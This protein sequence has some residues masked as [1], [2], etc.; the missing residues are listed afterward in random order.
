MLQ[1]YDVKGVG[2]VGVKQRETVCRVGH[3]YFYYIAV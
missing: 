2:T 3:I 1:R